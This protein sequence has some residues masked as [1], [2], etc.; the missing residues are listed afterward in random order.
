M[1]DF[2]AWCDAESLTVL[3]ETPISRAIG[4]MRNHRVALCRFLEEGRI[5][6]HTNW[7]E[8]EL[9]REAVG[10]KNW[11]FVGSDEGGIVNATFVSLIASCQLHGLEPFAYLRD[12]FCSLPS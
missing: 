10:R 12:L 5:P 1:E 11:L 9:R 3:D 8:R 2:E 4:H 6:I 7:S